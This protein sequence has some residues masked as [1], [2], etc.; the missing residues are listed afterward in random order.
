[1]R[2]DLE[3]G[4]R[5]GTDSA[6][7]FSFDLPCIRVGRGDDCELSVPTDL[8]L[9]RR[10]CSLEWHVGTLFLFPLRGQSDTILNSS[11]VSRPLPLSSGDIIEVGGQVVKVLFQQPE[12]SY[13]SGAERRLTLRVTE[14]G[15][16]PHTVDCTHSALR[17]CQGTASDIYI[18]EAKPSR[19]LVSDPVEAVIFWSAA[20]MPHLLVHKYSAPIERNGEPVVS[21]TVLTEGDLLTLGGAQIEVREIISPAEPPPPPLGLLIF[22]G[23]A[24]PRWQWFP[25]SRVEVGSAK[26]SDIVLADAQL[27]SLCFAIE[28]RGKKPTLIPTSAQHNLYVNYLRLTAPIELL[29]GDRICFGELL[30]HVDLK[31]PPPAKAQQGERRIV[32][33]MTESSEADN[34]PN[35]PREVFLKG[36]SVRLGTTP[37][38]EVDWPTN[39]ELLIDMTV[40]WHPNGTPFLHVGMWSAEVTLNGQKLRRCTLAP[41]QIGATI[42]AA[43]TTAVLREI[44]PRPLAQPAQ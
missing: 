40:L 39:D 15:G 43:G 20:G 14:P 19:L 25:R 12:L 44:V 34:D 11:R 4:S 27:P 37:Q 3:V 10:Q 13:P 8:L 9:S 26:G 1:M 29:D 28:R 18:G 42:E 5:G 41:L 17:L 35:E 33:T 32:L 31:T 30:L 16:S 36:E 6:R 7:R 2:I 23:D 21:C 38:S 24:P 22:D